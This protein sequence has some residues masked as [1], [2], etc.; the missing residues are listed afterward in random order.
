MK[1]PDVLRLEPRFL[2][3]Q[4][5]FVPGFPAGS[6][7]NSFHGDL[8]SV[9]GDSTLRRGSTYVRVS[10]SGAAVIER[11]SRR[12]SNVRPDPDSHGAQSGR[13]NRWERPCKLRRTRG[14]QSGPVVPGR[15]T[16]QPVIPMCE[17]LDLKQR[18]TLS[19]VAPDYQ[20]YRVHSVTRG[21]PSK[22]RRVTLVIRSIPDRHRSIAS[23]RPITRLPAW[24]QASI[25]TQ[26][27]KDG[28]HKDER[29]RRQAIA[30]F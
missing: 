4:L 14:A 17:A 10:P 8:L 7:T 22:N 24:R 29:T 25:A 23:C 30:V 28:L 18:R 5:A 1:S 21:T 2:P 11:G 27:T 15:R 12:R 13:R 19:G 16:E 6:G 3:N 26:A 20:G 9:E